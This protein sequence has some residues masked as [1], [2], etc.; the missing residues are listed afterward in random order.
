M[1]VGRCGCSHLV[2]SLQLKVALNRVQAVIEKVWSVLSTNT[3]I[4]IDG[5][6]QILEQLVDCSNGKTVLLWLLH[7]LVYIPKDV[8]S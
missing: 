1:T 4:L 8:D 2:T 5:N 3:D 6:V 7:V